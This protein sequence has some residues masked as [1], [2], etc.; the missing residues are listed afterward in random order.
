M[1]FSFYRLSLS[2]S[3]ILFFNASNTT[4]A[5]QNL[6]SNTRAVSGYDVVEYFN[7]NA[8]QGSSDYKAEFSGAVY[9]FKNKANLDLFKAKPK[10][11]VPQ[12]GG[13]CSYAM[14]KSGK[15]VEINPESFSI[16]N[17][18]LYLFYKTRFVDTKS[19]WLKNNSKLKS[20][21]DTN[22]KKWLSN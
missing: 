1:L 22:W 12:Y 5:Q 19:K 2:I 3:L 7:N 13:W 10:N 18:K 4:F 11:Y 9:Y 6:D 17:D 8:V 16:E 15:L 14:G 21:A 20:K